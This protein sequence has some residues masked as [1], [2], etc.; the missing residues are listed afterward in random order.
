MLSDTL[1][2]SPESCLRAF[3]YYGTQLFPK[4]GRRSVPG[5]GLQDASQGP[6]TVMGHNF[7]PGAVVGLSQG[8]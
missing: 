8:L 4:S 6:L 2:V 1:P 7:S 3:N 5:P